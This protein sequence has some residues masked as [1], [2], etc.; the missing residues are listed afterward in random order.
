LKLGATAEEILMNRKARILFISRGNTARCRLGAGFF[1]KDDR[2]QMDG[3]STAEDPVD[4]DPLV[5]EVM[6]EVG[7]DI[8]NQ[9]VC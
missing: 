1:P 3:A 8:S 9:W 7:I 4:D 5:G 2:D 6:Q